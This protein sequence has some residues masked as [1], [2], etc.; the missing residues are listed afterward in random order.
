MSLNI[1]Q[2]ITLDLDPAYR[3]AYLWNQAFR[4]KVS[5]EASVGFAMALAQS[6]GT[7]FTISEDILEHSDENKALN[8]QFVERFLKAMLWMVGGNQIHIA[9][10]KELFETIK[11]TYSACGE[12][13]FD[14]ELIGEK[15]YGSELE[16]IHCELADVPKSSGNAQSLGGYTD[17]CRVGFDLGGSDRKCSATIDGKVVHTEEVEW[18]PYFQNDPAWHLEGIKD[19]IRRAAAKLPRVDAI[20]GSAAGVYLDNQ[21]KIASLFR[22]IPEEDFDSKVKNIFI[23][24]KAEWDVPIV[25]VNDGDVTALNGA[26]SCGVTPCMGLAMG[27]S[28]AVGY[29]DKDA[30]ITGWLNELAFAPVDYREN[31]P[32]DEWSGDE[33]CGVQF[34]SQQAV[35][36]LAPAAGLEFEKGMPFPEQLKEVQ[37]L[38]K[39]ND[40][41]ARKIYETIGAYLGYSI[42][43]YGEFYEMDNLLI[44]GRVTS[45]EGGEIILEKAR[46]VL[47][48]EFPELSK[49]V[50]FHIP[51]ETDKRHGQAVTA[52]SLAPIN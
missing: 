31:G 32:V 26:Q 49:T 18:D 46:E 9:G 23:D 6:N 5:S 17:G 11:N 52:A 48:L 24:L 13:K 44:L 38:M 39:A 22:G 45:G 20:G 12:R 36:R 19:S 43:H 42:P 7:V 15:I 37:K 16:F 47:D 40:P 10:P 2:K 8:Q 28:E 50:S 35:A 4:K 41:R 1:E 21:V 33:G 30:K 51:N 3:P 14:N 27:T 25:V 29:V 34:F